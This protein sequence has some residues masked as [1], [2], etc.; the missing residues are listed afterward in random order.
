MANDDLLPD[1]IARKDG[2]YQVGGQHFMDYDSA[3]SY[4][5]STQAL[6]GENWL[7]GSLDSINSYFK[8]KAAEYETEANYIEAM[9]PSLQEASTNA[10]GPFYE[11]ADNF[12]KK[13]EIYKAL[14]LYEQAIDATYEVYMMTPKG[15]KIT[16]PGIF[17]SPALFRIAEIYF[18]LKDYRKAWE[19]AEQS[20]KFNPCPE[21]M[22]R[23]A[24][25]EQA[26]AKRQETHPEETHI[27]KPFFDKQYAIGGAIGAGAVLILGIITGAGV[28]N[29][30]LPMIVGFAVGYFVSKKIIEKRGRTNRVARTPEQEAAYEKELELKKDIQKNLVEALLAVGSIKQLRKEA[31]GGYRE[32][33]I[34]LLQRAAE[35]GDATA[36]NELGQIYL[37][38]KTGD[39]G[40]AE[41]A[42]EKAA[43]MG[44]ADS[45]YKLGLMYL[46][47]EGVTV[48]KAKA[49]QWLEKALRDVEGDSYNGWRLHDYPVDDEEKGKV[50]YF[51]G[52]TYR[53]GV[54]GIPRDLQKAKLFFERAQSFGNK[55]A[56]Q[57]L[58]ELKKLK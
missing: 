7:G 55:D 15:E 52:E 28:G 38:Q 20:L 43:E 53:N 12:R 56:K 31:E 49:A 42:F 25:L 19:F 29:S 22:D 24:L 14:V 2:G 44:D 58:K 54:G 40:K 1:G 10:A 17:R 50:Y 37:N 23:S 47:G 34:A 5:N 8:G 18:E 36:Q 11:K 3:M 26:K 51:L 35:L 45:Q 48:D 46:D 13:G 30:I 27:K 33:R 4:R 41:Q 57:A 16:S 6:P 32:K 9:T 39:T 21:A